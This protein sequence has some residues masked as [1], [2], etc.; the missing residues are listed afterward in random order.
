M[1]TIKRIIPSL[2]L[3]AAGLLAP[4]Q[5]LADRAPSPEE[6][7]RIETVLRNEGFSNW[8]KIEL[9]EDDDVWAVDDAYASDGRKYDLKLDPDTLA[10]IEPD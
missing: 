7:S 2:V 3:A 10:I 1:P 9:D 8:G 5:L 6:R 4:G